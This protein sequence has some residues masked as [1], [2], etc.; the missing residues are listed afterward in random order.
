MCLLSKC[1]PAAL[2]GG[3]SF[4]NAGALSCASL[5]TLSPA[6]DARARLSSTVFWV[7][8]SVCRISPDLHFE[9]RRLDTIHFT[10][11]QKAIPPNAVVLIPMC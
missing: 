9:N 10:R 1:I 7:T 11:T 2:K 8:V 5:T 4:L 3:K 6:P